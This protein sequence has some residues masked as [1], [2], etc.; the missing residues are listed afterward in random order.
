MC[1]VLAYDS[2]L[3][4]CCRTSYDQSA[5]GQISI[6]GKSCGNGTPSFRADTGGT[7]RCGYAIARRPQALGDSTEWTDM[8]R[9]TDDG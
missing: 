2:G 1:L 5:K 6:R 9:S 8:Q 7:P 3:G 4:V